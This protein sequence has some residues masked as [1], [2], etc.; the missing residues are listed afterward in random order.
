[1]LIDRLADIDSAKGMRH[2]AEGVRIVYR[3]AFQDGALHRS[4]HMNAM[5]W[6]IVLRV[7]AA[8]LDA[9]KGR[10]AEGDG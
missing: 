5:T 6:W 1:M 4:V 7:G 3:E 2:A 8:I 10:E 9:I